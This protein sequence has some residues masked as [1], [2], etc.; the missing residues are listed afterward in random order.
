M[1]TLISM[2]ASTVSSQPMSSQCEAGVLPA[3]CV[4]LYSWTKTFGFG[5]RLFYF[6]VLLQSAEQRH[7]AL[8]QQNVRIYS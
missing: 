1:T 8:L 7:C 3:R 6:T 4:L 2:A 5:G